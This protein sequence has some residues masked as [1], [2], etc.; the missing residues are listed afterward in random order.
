MHNIKKSIFKTEVY[1]DVIPSIFDILA[2]ATG[3]GTGTLTITGGEPLEV[4]SLF[5][6][7]TPDPGNFNNFNFSSPVAVGSLDPLHLTRNGNM[8][9][10]GSGSGVSTYTADPTD[11]GSECRITV[12][13]RSSGLTDGIGDF[14]DAT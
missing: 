11:G 10:D 8:T 12:T 6:E 13:A 5:F 14:T 3:P 9:L 2:V 1:E 4:I 7:V